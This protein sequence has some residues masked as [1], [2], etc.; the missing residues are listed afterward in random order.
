MS[1]KLKEIGK[2]N[3]GTKMKTQAGRRRR[4]VVKT[5][6]KNYRQF[7]VLQQRK[8]GKGDKEER[9]TQTGTKG[10]EK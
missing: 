3:F 4:A 10:K 8:G 1:R 5:G 2:E 9:D 7:Q 6:G